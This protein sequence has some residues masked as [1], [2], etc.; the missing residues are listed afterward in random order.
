MRAM[1]KD[2][3]RRYQSMAELERD[4]DR[5]L[6]GDPNVG[7]PLSEVTPVAEP[8]KVGA[9]W[10]L[11]IGAIVIIGVGLAL[12]LAR[13]EEEARNRAILEASQPPAITNQ[14]VLPAPPAQPPPPAPAQESPPAAPAP[15]ASA[16][17]AQ[18][19]SP[20]R[21]RARRPTREGLVPGLARAR[22]SPSRTY[23]RPAN[24]SP[25]T[26]TSAA[27]AGPHP[28]PLPQTG[29]GERGYGRPRP[30]H[31]R[32]PLAMRCPAR[33]SFALSRLRE[34]VGVR[35][36]AVARDMGEGL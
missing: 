4:L 24:T 2:R 20:D 33:Q 22:P 1:E 15:A 19:E 11:G 36:D 23:P 31:G 5:L 17:A 16:P 12:A 8:V 27:R 10:H 26:P 3:D 35:S 6:A 34:R 14:G 9:R 7:F 18:L 13:T 28:T 29:E 21:R 32:G 25:P 30:R